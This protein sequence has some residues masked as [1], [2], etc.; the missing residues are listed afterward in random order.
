[1]TSQRKHKKQAQSLGLSERE[2]RLAELVEEM[3]ESMRWMWVLGYSNQYLV[4][5][6]L[7]IDKADRDEILEASTRA[8]DRDARLHEWRERLAQI[9]GEAVRQHRAV[10]RARQD[11]VAG[12]PRPNQPDL[13]QD[14]GDA[15]L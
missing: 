15:E 12:D 11:L 13:E 4:N 5:N 6:F 1:M 8:V 14:A 10:D 7:K 3:L 9:K 2:L